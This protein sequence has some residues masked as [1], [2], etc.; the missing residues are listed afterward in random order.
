MQVLFTQSEEFGMT[1]GLNIVRGKV[2]H[3]PKI[4]GLKIPHMGWNSIK[5][6]KKAPL[7]EDTPRGAYLYFVHSYYVVPEENVVATTTEYGVEFA[8]SIWKE[9]IFACQFHPEKSQSTGLAILKK[10]KDMVK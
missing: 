8:S 10:F 1:P 2:V 5:I 7:L 3:F 4:R 6:L 9:N